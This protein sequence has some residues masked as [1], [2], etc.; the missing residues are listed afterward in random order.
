MML[1]AMRQND[2]EGAR[3]AVARGASA[4][5]T[6]EGVP[7]LHLAACAGKIGLVRELLAAGANA[8][9]KDKYGRTALSYVAW[10]GYSDEHDNVLEAL[11]RAGA[12][13]N[14]ADSQGQLPLDLAV[15]FLNQRM[16]TRLTTLGARCSAA[17]RA[18]LQRSQSRMEPHR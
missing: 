1:Q 6:V 16:I 8:D 17:S 14:A 9:A 2:A 4:N 18:L 5:L 13:V 11:T 10:L 15:H 7:V 12:D 3:N